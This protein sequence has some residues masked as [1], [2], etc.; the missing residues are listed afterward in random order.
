MLPNIKDIPQEVR[1]Q[2]LLK[3][4]GKATP[5][6][7][8][9]T[10][11]YLYM[12]RK[13]QRSIPDK[14]MEKLL[15]I[16]DDDTLASIPYFAP[17]V[18][19]DSIK[20]FDVTR[21][22]KLL[23]EWAEA[24]PASAAVLLNNLQLELE[25]RGL[26]GKAIVVPETAIR[27]YENYLNARVNSGDLSRKTANDRLRYLRLA[28]EE[29]NYTI[30]K[31]SIHNLIRK[32][33]AV[34][35]GVADHMYKSLKLFAREIIQDKELVDSIPRPRIVWSSPEAPQWEDICR[36][37]NNLPY[38]SPPR[39]L[40]L[41]AAST[42]IRI[43]TIYDLRLDNIRGRTIWLWKLRHSKRTYFSFITKKLAIELKEYLEY[44]NTMLE[45]TNRKSNKLFPFKPRRLR[46]QLYQAMDQTLGYRFQLKQLR[47]RFAEH[48]S[49]YLS[50]LEL[51]VLM[52]HASREVVEKHYLLRDEIENLQA[53]YDR[54][55]GE[56][57]C[58]G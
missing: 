4:D 23:I 51:Q 14:I 49:H 2:L 31:R 36:L 42:G 41:I 58:L 44:R 39:I 52:G 30:T 43:Q 25:K 17:Y 55:M 33:Q 24:N 27:E 57:P 5:R 19:F 37:V 50:T 53:K 32:Y 21:I 15:E 7:L 45:A 28:L 40:L 29:L 35:P 22:T 8:G 12:M 38:A 16:A 1:R 6:L 9:V 47:K 56:V 13:G 18:S 10:R 26:V 34:Q 48:L 20:R 3:L 54:A 11:Q 46:E